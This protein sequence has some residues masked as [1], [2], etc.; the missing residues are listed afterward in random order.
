MKQTDP[1]ASFHGQRKPESESLGLAGG[2]AKASSASV[3][4]DKGISTGDQVA[5]AEL[6]M[7]GNLGGSISM[8]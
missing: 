8:P 6:N 2:E 3:K 1:M 7:K 5:S 4:F